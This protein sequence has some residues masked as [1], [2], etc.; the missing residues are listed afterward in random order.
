VPPEELEQATRTIAP[1]LAH[2]SQ[3]DDAEGGGL[4]AGGAVLFTALTSIGVGFVL[5]CSLISSMLVPGG[6]VTRLQGLAVVS[7]S[8]IEIGRWRSFARTFVAWSPSI[9]WIVFLITSPRIQGLIPAPAAP[10]LAM[11]VG[12]GAQLIGAFG[13]IAR[14]ARGV[15]DWIAGTWVVPR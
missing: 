12:L 9:A 14:P 13:T 8:G 3:S 2:F 1:E 7:R 4:P 6:V 10:I 15:H 11:S 5:A